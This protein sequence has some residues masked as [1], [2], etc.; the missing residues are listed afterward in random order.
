MHYIWLGR[1]NALELQLQDAGAVIDHSAITRVE[2]DLGGGTVLDSDTNAAWFDLTKTDRL[3]FKLG[4]SSVAAGQYR[5]RLI[6]YT[7]DYPNG[8]IWGDQPEDMV[9]N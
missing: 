1:D 5:A 7:P 8:L 6:I 4:Q 9:F 3:V 2:V